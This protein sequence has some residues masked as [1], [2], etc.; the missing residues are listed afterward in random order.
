M[1][2]WKKC[3]GFDLYEVSSYGRVKSMIREEERILTQAV[4]D[5]FYSVMLWSPD[6]PKRRG[7]ARLVCEAFNGP[8]PKKR[9]EVRHIDG[10]RW[11]NYASNLAWAP[12]SAVSVCR[13]TEDQVREIRRRLK[14]ETGIKLAR[15]FKVT[16][17]TISF[18]K[19]RLTWKHVR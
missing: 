16:P 14:K 18:I 17:T 3:P 8:P 2:T 4:D 9:S 15:E 11:N 19:D 1:E 7:V 6:G 10:K 13:L 12:H 5:G